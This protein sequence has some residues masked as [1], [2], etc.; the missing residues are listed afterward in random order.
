[1]TAAR[2]ADKE[3]PHVSR[4]KK[5]KKKVA[6]TARN[7]IRAPDIISPRMVVGTDQLS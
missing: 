3:G 4:W 6:F 2:V 7:M 1:L 5:N